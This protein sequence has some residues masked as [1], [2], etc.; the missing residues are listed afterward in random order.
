MTERPGSVEE[1]PA[2]RPEHGGLSPE[3]RA[4]VERAALL[5]DGIA[6][7]HRSPPE[8]AAVLLGTTPHAVERARA[9]LEHPRARAVALEL[10]A[11][12]AAGRDASPAAAPATPA[13]RGPEE[14]IAAARGRPGGLALVFS[15]AA[16]SAAISFGVR[17]D[18]VLAARALAERRGLVADLPADA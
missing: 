9:A 4:L 12:P 16:E 8:C 1:P 13:P 17:P 2:P 10:L 18:L 5:S 14:L 6:H 11:R 15:A 7:L 3:V